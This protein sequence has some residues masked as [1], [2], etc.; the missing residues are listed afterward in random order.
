MR[1]NNKQ[2]YHMDLTQLSLAEK[3]DLAVTSAEKTLLE[4]LLISPEMLVRRAIL[5]NQNLTTDMV[6]LLAFDVTENVSYMA[7]THRK[8]TVSRTFKEP[9]SICV[10]CK[11]DERKISCESCPYL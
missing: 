2:D 1:N 6:N 10:Q 3:L 4:M 11:I 7:T 8:C 9:V 5:R